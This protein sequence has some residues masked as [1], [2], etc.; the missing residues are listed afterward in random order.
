MSFIT[1]R[2][3]DPAGVNADHRVSDRLS[4]RRPPPAWYETLLITLRAQKLR[5]GDLSPPEPGF[6]WRVLT[7][8]QQQRWR[9]PIVQG[10]PGLVIR[11]DPGWAGECAAPHKETPLA[12]GRGERRI[13]MRQ[14]ARIAEVFNLPLSGS[15]VEGWVKSRSG[16]IP[17]RIN[18]GVRN[19]RH[20]TCFDSTT[21]PSQV[22]NIEVGASSRK[23]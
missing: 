1:R 3:G 6:L 18:M 5:R 13:A 16:S 2:G 14:S 15:T 21:T 8:Q 22:R 17:E 23:R 4:N 7:G 19:K 12:T 11:A 10:D 9:G 20:R